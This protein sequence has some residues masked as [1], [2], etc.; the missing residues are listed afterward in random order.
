MKIVVVP[1]STLP[2]VV[3][4]LTGAVRDQQVRDVVLSFPKTSRPSGAA[5]AEAVTEFTDFFSQLAATRGV[6]GTDLTQV[7]RGL[8]TAFRAVLRRDRMVELQ[9]DLAGSHDREK[10]L[11]VASLLA[12]HFRRG[13][14]GALR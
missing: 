12:A 14:D 4:V 9:Y 11:E 10:Q 8:D 6:D 3:A 5:R 1:E 7:A 13:T 2:Q